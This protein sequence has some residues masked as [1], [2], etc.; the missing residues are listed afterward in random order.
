MDRSAEIKRLQE[1]LQSLTARH[2]LAALKTGTEIEDMDFNEIAF[3]KE[4]AGDLPLI[5]K[6]GGPEARNDIRACLRIQVNTILG[7][8][9][10]TVY[11]LTN[12]VSAAREIMKE[13]KAEARLAINI[14]SITAVQNLSA[15]LESSSMQHLHQI[16]VGRSDL[17]RSLH[18]PI[19]DPEVI[20]YSANI[21]KKANNRGLLTSI[22]GGLS[23]SNIARLCDQI[24][25][26]RFNS[27]HMVFLNTPRF[28]EN[29]GSHLL[30][31]LNFEEILYQV[32]GRI[33]PEKEAHY[34][35]RSQTLRRRMNGLKLLRKNGLS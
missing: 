27:R 30:A 33:F 25:A 8:M 22:G 7:P 1:K 2:H 26:A 13:M 21:V 5:V 4:V 24:P 15:M 16:T 28:R 3:L 17:S 10:E 12:F 29:P 34:R 9:I 35:E 23:L 31:G 19:D 14:E 6:I 32:L 18:L 20:S 11:A